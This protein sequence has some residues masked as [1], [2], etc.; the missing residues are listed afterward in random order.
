MGL[1]NSPVNEKME[2]YEV[3]TEASPNEMVDGCHSS[4]DDEED[5]DPQPGCSRERSPS[6]RPGTSKSSRGRKRASVEP[7]MEISAAEQS[8][9]L[10][11]RILLFE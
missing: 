10:T 8:V 4:K 1:Q 3:K 2:V 5:Q 6:P 11:G 7:C 9:V